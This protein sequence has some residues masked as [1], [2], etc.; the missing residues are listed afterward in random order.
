MT[1]QDRKAFGELRDF[2]KHTYSHD[3][4]T[5]EEHRDEATQ[6]YEEAYVARTEQSLIRDRQ[7]F[8]NRVFTARINRRWEAINALPAELREKAVMPEP[9]NLIPSTLVLPVEFPAIDDPG[10]LV[11]I[12]SDETG[13]SM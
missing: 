10:S 5:A 11:Q 13:T 8:E 1:P 12:M 2:L 9:D 3:R 4:A 7:D 6:A